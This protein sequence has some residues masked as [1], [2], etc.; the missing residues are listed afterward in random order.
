MALP[1]SATTM[2]ASRRSVESVFV[3]E[4]VT[5]FV[6]PGA[7]VALDSG[8]PFKA[9]VVSM[10]GAVMAT[11]ASWVM[12]VT[13]S[14]LPVPSVPTEKWKTRVSPSWPSRV[15]VKVTVRLWPGG[16]VPSGKDGPADGTEEEVSE[17]PKGNVPR[18]ATSSI[19]TVALLR[20]WSV[21]VR[22]LPGTVS[23]MVSADMESGVEEMMSG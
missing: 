5:S 16:I 4:S 23:A 15:P 18:T 8:E 13:A 19:G 9:S 2:V 6:V 3:Y 22:D 7:S 21:R 17:K 12:Y 11:L 1:E 20:T 10:N 14:P